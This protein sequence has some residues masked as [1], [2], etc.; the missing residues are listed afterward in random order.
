[1]H[2]HTMVRAAAKTLMWG[3]FAKHVIFVPVLKNIL[4]MICRCLTNHDNCAFRNVDI[5]DHCIVFCDTA[6]DL[7]W[8]DPAHAFLKG[9][10]PVFCLAN[11]LKLIWVCQ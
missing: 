8:G 5:L 1:M 2:A 4:I 11:M 6:A 7:N 3:R 9:K 10:L